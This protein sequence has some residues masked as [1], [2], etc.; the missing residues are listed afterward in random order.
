MDV[1]KV[2]WAESQPKCDCFM[3]FSR[4]PFPFGVRGMCCCSVNAQCFADPRAL[5]SLPGRR[6]ERLD[7][8]RAVFGRGRRLFFKM[9]WLDRLG[10]YGWRCVP[11]L[12]TL[13]TCPDHLNRVCFVSSASSSTSFVLNPFK[14]ISVKVFDPMF[15]ADFGPHGRFNDQTFCKDIM[16][17]D[18]DLAT[19]GPLGLVS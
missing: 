17:I 14:L 11:T 5:I 18:V 2:I 6:F 7:S 16:T 12:V 1:L 10:T 13:S 19:T 8:S 4:R 9:S 3:S 15:A